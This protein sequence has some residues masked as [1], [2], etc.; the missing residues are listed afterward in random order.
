MRTAVTTLD[1]SN[2][3]VLVRLADEVRRDG[4]PRVLRRD[5]E[6]V[7]ILMPAPAPRRR[8]RRGKGWTPSLEDL[9]AFRS[10]A[11]SWHDM[12][13]DTLIADIYASRRLSR[14]PIDL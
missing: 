1:I 13:V 14:P 11:G 3:P 7:A 6:D 12:D 8:P 9:E 4:R 2:E 10:A 5:G